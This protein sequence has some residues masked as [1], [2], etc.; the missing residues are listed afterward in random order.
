MTIVA[1]VLRTELIAP[2]TPAIE[3]EVSLIVTTV[4][5]EVRSTNVVTGTTYSIRPAPCPTTPGA[6][7]NRSSAAIAAGIPAIA[8]TRRELW[9]EK[10]D[11]RGAN[12]Q[13]NHVLTGRTVS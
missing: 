5:P 6:A 13:L 12:I 8:G 4:S 2:C 1:L 10:R 3:P 7:E 9:R 11:S